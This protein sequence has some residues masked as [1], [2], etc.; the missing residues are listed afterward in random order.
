[1]EYTVLKR[2]KDV[3]RNQKALFAIASSFDA[4]GLVSKSTM[5]EVQ[6]A[7]KELRIMRATA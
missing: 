7:I 1:M 6:K 2:L 5:F 4:S 3:Q